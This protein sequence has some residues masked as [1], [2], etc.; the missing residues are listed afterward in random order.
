MSVHVQDDATLARGIY[1]PFNDY[2]LDRA[3]TYADEDVEW[4][5]IPLG[6]IFRSHDGFRE[7]MQ[8]WK[9]AFPDC[10]VDVKHQIASEDGVA[11]EFSGSAHNEWH[12][13]R[14]GHGD[15]SNREADDRDRHRHL[16]RQRGQVCRALVAARHPEPAATTRR[17]PPA[18]A[19]QNIT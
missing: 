11:S 9:T 14:G 13:S 7:F 6:Q 15:S 4:V 16:A 18:G 17:H 10:T 19:S 8:G 12:P 3:L 1:R 5:N 2:D